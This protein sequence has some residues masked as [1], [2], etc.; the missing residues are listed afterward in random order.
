M[1]N[2]EGSAGTKKVDYYTILPTPE[3]VA[4][5]GVIKSIFSV[6]TGESDSSI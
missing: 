3:N 4:P 2:I 1:V 5:T 6:L